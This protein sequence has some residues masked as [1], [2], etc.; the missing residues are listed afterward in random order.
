MR[1]FGGAGFGGFSMWVSDAWGDYE[2]LDCSGGEKLERWG[3]YV[4][5]RP[6]P[7]AIWQTPK[8][9]AWDL[10][11][12][13]YRRSDTGGGKWVKSRVPESWEIGYSDL[14]FRVKLMSFKHTGIFPEQAA[15]WDF[16]RAAIRGAH[17]PVN[18]LNLFAYTDAATLAAAS[19]G[20]SVCHVDAARGMVAWG[21]ENAAASGHSAACSS[22]AARAISSA[23][24]QRA[25][26]SASRGGVSGLR[27]CVHRNLR[28]IKP[29][30]PVFSLTVSEGFS[31]FN[32]V[33]PV[34]PDWR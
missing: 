24:S 31:I 27:P 21:K 26:P 3:S 33:S 13:V 23:R 25:K 12:A 17:R 4:L 19:A 28:M 16:I 14:R 2:L 15:N 5:R 8:G 20:A 7:Q 22:T 6:D 9:E 29:S 30:D 18:V 32:P 11:D 34:F 1:I 10:A